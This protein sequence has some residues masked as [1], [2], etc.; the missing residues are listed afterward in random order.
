MRA[1]PTDAN[2]SVILVPAVAKFATRVYIVDQVSPLMR[3][4]PSKLSASTKHTAPY[5]PSSPTQKLR[6]SGYLGRVNEVMNTF[7]VKSWAKA[8]YSEELTAV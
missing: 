3:N 2:P 8:N 6:Y 4:K 5:V 7:F 1:S